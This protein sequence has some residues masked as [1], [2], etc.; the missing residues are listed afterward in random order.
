MK[1]YIFMNITVFAVSQVLSSIIH[2]LCLSG[3]YQDLSL[4]FFV[5]AIG[6]FLAP[7]NAKALWGFFFFFGLGMAL[8]VR[9][10]MRKISIE[11]LIDPGIQK[12]ITRWSI[13][14]M[15]V[16]TVT[17]IQVRIVYRFIFPI[18]LIAAAAGFLTL[19]V[20]LFFGRRIWSF[21][22]ERIAA[23]YGTVTGTCSTGLLLLRVVD[24]DFK[25][26]VAIELA[27]MNVFSIPIIGGC[28]VLMNAPLWWNWSVG[29][30][31]LLLPGEPGV[32]PSRFRRL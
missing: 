15:I 10:F 19:L 18:F 16:A 24:P 11:R 30:T 21:N 17:A 20:V 14:F 28:T 31:A 5:R 4:I 9:F 25:T 27:I 22:L 12:R 29:I 2:S 23:I 26:P 3:A 1:K 6:K 8:F 32:Q 7:D 13:D